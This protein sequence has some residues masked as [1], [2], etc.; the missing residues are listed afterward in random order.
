MEA[1]YQLSYSPV[2][3]SDLSKRRGGH[4]I[5]MALGA[6]SASGG[7]GL[8]VDPRD[9]APEALEVVRCPAR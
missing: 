5:E 9:V 8:P 7:G 2:G 6:G 1:L 3:S 4:R